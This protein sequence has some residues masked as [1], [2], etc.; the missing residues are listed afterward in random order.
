[1]RGAGGRGPPSGVRLPGSGVA[2]HVAPPQHPV[3]RVQRALTL[4]LTLTLT[5]SLTLFL[6]LSTEPVPRG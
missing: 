1:M 3:P 4:T 6:N 2:V 5:L